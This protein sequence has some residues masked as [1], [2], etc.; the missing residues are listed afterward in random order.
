MTPAIIILLN[1]LC[2]TLIYFTTSK[3]ARNFSNSLIQ[4]LENRERFIQLNLKHI[5]SVFAFLLVLI[6]HYVYD[7]SISEWFNIPSPNVFFPVIIFSLLA[8][9]ISIYNPLE[10]TE[11][12][13]GSKNH[14][15][16]LNQSLN[17]L[18]VP[19][20]YF[21]IRTLYLVCYE[22]FFRLTL[23]ESLSI[24]MGTNPA[25]LVST[26][27]YGL[28]HQFSNKIEFYTSFVFGLVLCWLVIHTRSILP[29]I[30]IHLLLS[31]PYELRLIYHHK[32]LS[33]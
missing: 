16:Q 22:I 8:L 24:L 29:A 17:P 28:H 9:F 1:L 26:I 30:I 15:H 4:A 31:L 11:R 23:I 6:L 32:N 5:Q 20:S 18:P 7:I 21:P 27:L 10:N 19:A 2:F 3:A 25:I 33:L 13:S 14:S 12:V